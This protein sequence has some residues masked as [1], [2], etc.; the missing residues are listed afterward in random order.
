[1][2]NKISEREFLSR[3]NKPIEYIGIYE[4]D[5]IID[6]N[7]LDCEGI[8]IVFADEQYLIQSSSKGEDD[9]DFLY[10][11]FSQAYDCRKILASKSEPV[12]FVR[13]EEEKNSFRILRF[14]IGNRPILVTAIADGLLTV[15]ISHL[16]TN[17]EWLTFENNTLL[18]DK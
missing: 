10:Y 7:Q 12:H 1:M 18:N 11:R 2:L 4:L 3:T 16:D 14:Q 5:C 15:G 8:I 13:K 17:D 9:F 6:D